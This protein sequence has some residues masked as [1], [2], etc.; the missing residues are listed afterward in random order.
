MSTNTTLTCRIC[1]RT[2]GH[3][4]FTARE[5]MLGLGHTFTYLECAACRSLQL[6]DPPDDLSP[7]YPAGY[8]SYSTVAAGVRSSWKDRLRDRAMRAL[9]RHRS[10]RFDAAGWAIAQLSDAF[11]WVRPGLLHD[12]SRILDVGCG[13]GALLLLLQRCG[14]TDLTGVDPFIA[15]DIVHPGGIRIHKQE[16]AQ[17]EGA[18]DLIILSHAFEHMPDPLSM[19]VRIRE[20]LKPGGR[21]VIRIPVA[22]CFAWKHYGTH[23]VQ[24]D[25]PRHFFLHT[26]ASM[27]LLAERSGLVLEHQRYDSTA[28]QFIG[29]EKYLKGLPLDAPDPTITPARIKAFAK[30]A[31]ELN[32]TGA[33][34]TMS[35]YLAR[36]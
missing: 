22:D 6:L 32:R 17:H 3:R 8:Y 4:T 5:R 16:L 34:D 10:G 26:P 1:G 35:F 12:R 30:Q 18:Y 21:A 27:R 14:C 11:S 28:F 36:A 13:N 20:H 2:E 31:K 33:G 29:S 9:L 25:A 15:T 24:L 19:M 23:W 7:Y